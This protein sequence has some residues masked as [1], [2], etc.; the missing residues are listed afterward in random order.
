MDYIKKIK[1]RDLQSNSNWGTICPLV[2]RVAADYLNIRTP[3][4]SQF[5]MPDVLDI[6]CCTCWIRGESLLPTLI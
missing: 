2:E 6:Q 5:D 4:P 3:Y 1:N